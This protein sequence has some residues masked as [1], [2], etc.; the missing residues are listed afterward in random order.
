MWARF[1]QARLAWVSMTPLGRPVVPDVYI[2]RWT[3]SAATATGAA[4]LSALRSSARLVQPSGTD[5][6]GEPLV[7]AGAMQAR[8]SVASSP[9]VASSARATNDWSH[10]RAAASECSR[11]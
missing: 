11:M 2:S 4:G 5:Q 1:F 3:S 10:T 6:A 9:T 8:S 7:A